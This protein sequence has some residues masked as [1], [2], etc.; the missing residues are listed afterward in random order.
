M[1]KRCMAACMLVL[2]CIFLFGCSTVTSAVRLYV[3]EDG[4]LVVEQSVKI[5]LDESKLAELGRSD[6]EVFCE[7]INVIIEDYLDSF[8][9]EY[10][11]RRE[12]FFT[13]AKKRKFLKL[14]GN[15]YNEE[16]VKKSY[17]FYVYRQFSTIYDFLLYNN[18]DMLYIGCPNCAEQIAHTESEAEFVSKCLHCNKDTGGDFEYYMVQRIIDFPFVG[19]ITEKQGNF[20]TTYSQEILT[21]YKDLIELVNRD[22]E[23]LVGAIQSLFGVGVN[24]TLEDVDLKFQ[25]ITPYG[26]V[27]SNGTTSRKGGLY[28]H[29]W[30]INDLDQKIILYRMAARTTNWYVLALV[31]VLGLTLVLTIFAVV[32]QKMYEKSKEKLAKEKDKENHNNLIDRIR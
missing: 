24:P 23:P 8:Q 31:S 28:V 7:E 13:N 25:Y 1:L 2:C 30:D 32:K 6:Y 14:F 9:Y 19:E 22:N 11:S 5:E 10:E 26:R 16:V 3:Q 18:Y 17:G 20:T 12:E 21:V 29:T 4:S 15:G 27:H